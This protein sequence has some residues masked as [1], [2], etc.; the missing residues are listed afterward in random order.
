[1]FHV[2]GQGRLIRCFGGETLCVEAWGESALRVRAVQY[3]CPLEGRDG[4]LLDRPDG[5]AEI[6]I[7][8]DAATIANGRIRAEIT[9]GG[10]LVFFN[11][12]GELLLQEFA[13][14]RRDLQSKD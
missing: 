13:R 4:A 9:R 11:Q 14:N 3:G 5:K 10:K 6:I 12:K 2:D 7:R 1:M 8:G